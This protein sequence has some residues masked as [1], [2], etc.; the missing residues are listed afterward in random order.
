MLQYTLLQVALQMNHN[1]YQVEQEE[2]WHPSE[3][4]KHYSG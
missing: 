4:L 2:Y 3:E 1:S